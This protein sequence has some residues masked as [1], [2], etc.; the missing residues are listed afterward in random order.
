M[1]KHCWYSLTVSSI[2]LSF[3]LFFIP[4]EAQQIPVVNQSVNWKPGS[5]IYYQHDWVEVM[6]GDMPIVISVPHG[7]FLKPADIPDRTCKDEGGLVTVTDSY[8]I[9]TALA[10][11]L[12]FFKKYNHSPF[13]VIS[14]IARTKV[15]QNR[16]L[17]QAACGNEFAETA[18]RQFHNAVDTALALAVSEYGYAL[19]ID[20]H[21]HGH[22]NQRLELG[23]SLTGADLREAFQKDADLSFW[24]EN[25]SLQNLLKSKRTTF[26]K[27]VWGKHSFGSLI[28]KNG[29]PAV[30]SLQ[31]P[32]PLE[33]EKFFSGGYNTRR[34]TSAG[35][36]GVF[37]WQ[38]ECNFKGVRDSETSRNN[39]AEQFVSTY[40]RFIKK[41]KP[42]KKI[43]R[44]GS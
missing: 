3:F 41:N 4:A 24:N 13:I 38:I 32:F 35:Y 27:L 7:G 20:L 33:D 9:E 1:M 17:Y 28:Y 36:P 42:L 21:G 6:P 37:G 31:D 30:P 12:A 5:K 8:T 25:S 22:K 16:D 23:Y 10:I 19:Y 2:F 11:R 15:D 43:T 40:S 39:F 14:N 26:R 29:I 18:W 34:Y 44:T